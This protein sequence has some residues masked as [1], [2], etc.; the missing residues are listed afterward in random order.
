MKR[1]H[2]AALRSAVDE[3]RPLVSEAE[4]I[5][6]HRDRLAS[7]KKA[8]VASWRSR[9]VQVQR[10]GS[11]G[12]VVLGFGSRDTSLVQ[13]IARWRNLLPLTTDQE[14]LLTTLVRPAAKALRDA[15]ATSGARR[16][17]ARSATKES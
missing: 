17:F 9:M 10:A 5:T 16:L 14:Q 12:W 8:A 3:I 11:V 2:R 6:A 4:R 15:R 1:D 13:P 7:D